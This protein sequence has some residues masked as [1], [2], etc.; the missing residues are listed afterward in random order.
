MTGCFINDFILSK[1]GGEVVHSV[2]M[3]SIH[4]FEGM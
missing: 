1:S 4:T 2:A 3:T